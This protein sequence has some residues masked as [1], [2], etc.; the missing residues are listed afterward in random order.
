MEQERNLS[1]TPEQIHSVSEQI[2]YKFTSALFHG[3][4]TA[5]KEGTINSSQCD[6]LEEI[7]L[8][9]FENVGPFPSKTRYNVK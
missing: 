8:K 4:M 5:L 1:I 2:G 9:E 7:L 3:L 6:R